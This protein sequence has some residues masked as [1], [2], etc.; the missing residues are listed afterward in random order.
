MNFAALQA[1]VVP[2]VAELFATLAA[3]NPLRMHFADIAGKTMLDIVENLREEG[4][5]QEAIAAALG[6]TITGYRAKIRRLRELYGAGAERAEDEPRTLLERV[7]AFVDDAGG[8]VPEEDILAHFRGVKLD[9]LKGVIQ[10]LVRSGALER[11]HDRKGREYRTVPRTLPGGPGLQD[12]EVMLYRD[13]PL[14]LAELAQR[15][16]TSVE[17]VA[18]FVVELEAADRLLRGTRDGEVTWRALAYHIPLD[19]GEGY[20][21]AIWDHL[22][23]VIR[24][25]CKKL[26]LGRHGASLRDKTGGATFTFHLPED[27]P[28]YAEVSGYLAESRL[29][30]EDW[31]ARAEALELPQGRPVKQVTVY[32]GQLVED[33]LLPGDDPEE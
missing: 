21:A 19:A 12:A 20:E 10:F 33:H 13:G 3:Q 18:G 14:T 32:V 7:Y 27:H 2:L 15:L 25:I 8:P 22:A 24:S 31:L 23:A 4:V 29:R 9:S 28:L 11:A 1:R 5:S 17:E 6:L 16:D 30:F 26:R